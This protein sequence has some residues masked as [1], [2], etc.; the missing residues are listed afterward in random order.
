MNYKYPHTIDNG[1]GEEI[2]FLKLLS[3]PA[4]DYLEVTNFVLPGAGPP[5]HVHF[6]QTESLTVLEGKIAVQVKHKQ[7]EYFGPGDTVTFPPKQYHKFW[8]AG[9]VP[10]IC[11]GWAKPAHNMEYFLT[12]IYAS[13]KANG[14]KRPA[15]FDAAFLLDRYRNE[16][17]MDEI[18]VFVKKII[19]PITLFFGKLSGKH[20]KFIDAPEPIR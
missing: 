20:K 3:D 2:T 8:N 11:H 13:V 6:K 16:F 5:M 14:G 17:D 18:P 19:F 12:Q 9:T 1:S 7:P 10:L 15:S 4:G